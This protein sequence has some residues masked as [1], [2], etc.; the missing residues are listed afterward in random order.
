MNFKRQIGLDNLA[1]KYGYAAD[2]VMGHTSEQKIPDSWV[3]TAC[4]YCS[5][6]CG[7]FV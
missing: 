1:E 6:G 2:A 5:V 4:G 7:M 3:S